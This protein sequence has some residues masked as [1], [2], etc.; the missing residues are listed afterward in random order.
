MGNGPLYAMG[1]AHPNALTLSS[2]TSTSG[3]VPRADAMGGLATGNRAGKA[4]QREQEICTPWEIV[5]V[6]L[7]VW[8]EGIALDPCAS[9]KAL[10]PATQ[11]YHGI[12]IATG[13]TNKDGEEIIRW[14]GSGL[15]AP[16]L[17][18]SYVNPPYEDLEE[19][20]FKSACEYA[21]GR[22][23]QI[24]LFPVRPNRLWWTEYMSTIPTRIAWL[25]PLVFEG[26]EHG[27]PAPLVL[28]YTGAGG[29]IDAPALEA[30]EADAQ[31]PALPAM[32]RIETFR[33]AVL[34]LST[35][36][37]GPLR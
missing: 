21:K 13:R 15:I 4:A 16:W 32:D 22:T 5:D 6:C 17:Q 34:P 33:R 29:V 3:V 35:F 11:A 9:R 26:Y 7:S 37:G 36:V 27:F 2:T 25:K 19:W 12:K 24:L 14:G 18:R 28:V 8:P 10:V 20:L 1:G 30:F 23:E 31:T